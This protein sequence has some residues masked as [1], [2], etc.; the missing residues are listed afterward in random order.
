MVKLLVQKNRSS[1]RIVRSVNK[2]FTFFKKF[3][4]LFV[5]KKRLFFF[6]KS[7]WI[8]VRNVK[9]QTNKTVHEQS[10]SLK[11]Y[12]IVYFA[13]FGRFKKNYRFFIS[14][15]DIYILSIIYEKFCPLKKT[16]PSLCQTLPLF[17]DLVYSL[18]SQCK[19]WI[20]I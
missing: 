14:L 3:V 11:R 5:H 16:M 15:S 12:Q 1:N 18:K 8:F 9:K 10:R 2:K 19:I 20:S 7:F 4:K 13:S 17:S 6:S